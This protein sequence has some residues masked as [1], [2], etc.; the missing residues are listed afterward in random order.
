MR[1][2]SLRS[3][4]QNIPEPTRTHRTQPAQ[5]IPA[6]ILSRAKDLEDSTTVNNSTTATSHREILHCVQNDIWAKKVASI[7]LRTPISES[8]NAPI[9]YEST[10][11][12]QK[13]LDLAYRKSEH[14]RIVLKRTAS[15]AQLFGIGRRWPLITRNKKKSTEVLF[16]LLCLAWITL[17]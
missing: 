11:S 13:G 12:C 7:G 15:S 4:W 9:L 17:K 8:Q 10:V 5:P 2:S 1:D 6:V 3:E 16:S 14:P